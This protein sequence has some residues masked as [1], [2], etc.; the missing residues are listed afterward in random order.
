MEN[1]ANLCPTIQEEHANAI[2]G[3]LEKGPD[4]VFTI[5][6]IFMDVDITLILGVQ[7]TIKDVLPI[8]YL[9]SLILHH[10]NT[11]LNPKVSL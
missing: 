1:L 3:F 9:D 8:I 2:G 11:N 4:M 10:N 6:H 7:I 5:I